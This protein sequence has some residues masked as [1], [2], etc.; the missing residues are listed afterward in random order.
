M[1]LTVAAV[2]H[3]LTCS[4]DTVR[5]LIR[6]GRLD[7]YRLSGERGPWR[8]QPAAIDAYRDAQRARDPWQR[9]RPRRSR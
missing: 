3:E 1:D 2:A 8:V 9:T 6:S 5:T 7:A 4:P